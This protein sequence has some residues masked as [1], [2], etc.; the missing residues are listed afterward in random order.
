M[1]KQS[2]SRRIPVLWR[3]KKTAYPH[4]YPQGQGISPSC[5]G[6]GVREYWI[7]D[8]QQRIVMVYVFDTEPEDAGIY[9]FE[10]EITPSLYPDLK[11]RIADMVV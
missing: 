11:I 9:S 8:L 10:D 1:L 6:A 3:V 7:I 2:L 5:P 4:S